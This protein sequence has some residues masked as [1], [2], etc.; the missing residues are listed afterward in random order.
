M[1]SWYS[2]LVGLLDDAG[3]RQFWLLLGLILVMALIDM[4]GVASVIPFLAV[5]ANPEI[6]QE[7]AWLSRIQGLAGIETTQ[8]LLVAL[9]STTFVFVVFGQMLKAVTSYMI[10]RFSQQNEARLS[11]RL[12]RSY[13]F[14]P[15]VWFLTQNSSE[16]VKSLLSDVAWVM[17]D[18]MISAL[19]IISSGIVFIFLVLLLVF[20]DPVAA[21][22]G[23]IVIGGAYGAVYFVAHG[24]LTRLGLERFREQEARFRVSTEV[25]SG[26]KPVKVSG[27][28]RGY[29]SRFGHHANRYARLQAICAALAELPRHLLEAVVF[30][31][32]ILFLLVLLGLHSGRLE[33][34]IPIVGLYAFAG[35][36]M[37]PA[38]QAIYGNY[39]ALR[40]VAPSIEALH[41]RL[42]EATDSGRR[43]PGEGD[44][45][46]A[47]ESVPL[48]P[49]VKIELDSLSFRYPGADQDALA[50]LDL[51]I[52]ANTSVGIVGTTGSGKSTLV[53]LMLG[54]LR[55]D[56]G[57][58]RVDGAAIDERN[59]R[60]WQ[61][62]I[63]YVPQEIFLADDT[64]AA[65]IAFGV[66]PLEVDHTAVEAAARMAEL[67][68]F[69][70]GLSDGYQTH[71]GERGVRLSGGQR[72]RIGIARALYD[73][74][75]VLIF[76]EATS[77]LDNITEASVME[78]IHNLRHLKTIVIVAHRL[79]TLRDCDIIHVLEAGRIVDSGS[80]SHL[81]RTHHMFKMIN[82]SLPAAEAG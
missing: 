10:T 13:L 48:T 4:I 32:M 68:G 5:L 17:H 66:P 14:K 53:D 52:G 38:L 23:A 79:T 77:S 20:V 60:R 18:G 33:S 76:D 65:N 57:A 41:N 35:I 9:G 73:D 74:P 45:S 42:P 58:I 78:A 54:L 63:G 26:I 72:Q 11:Q 29:L 46:D 25:I 2:S 51:I 50:G 61:R 3:R 43:L 28:E 62:A 44:D 1:F 56:A 22:L 27:C 36:R 49:R 47:P 16:I 15:Y 12:L 19:R 81:S 55:P 37:F 6:V 69:V 34:V 21:L 80:Y 64:I 7:N 31:G 75:P 8:G 71:V 24:H 40:L 70:E 30:G 39:V 59:V 67:H 82:S